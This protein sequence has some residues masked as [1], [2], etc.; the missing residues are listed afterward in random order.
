MLCKVC[1]VCARA[2]VHAQIFIDS[3]QPEPAPFS[4]Y[5]RTEKPYK[6]YTPYTDVLKALI[7]LGSLCVGFVLGVAFLCW[8][9][10]AEGEKRHD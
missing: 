5:A 7:L 4:F 2:R 6:P 10:S 3:R 9:G 1:K 8:V